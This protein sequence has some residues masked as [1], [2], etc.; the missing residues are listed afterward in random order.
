MPIGQAPCHSLLFV[1]R[2]ASSAK[3]IVFQIALQKF[4]SPTIL[5]ISQL[6]EVYSSLQSIVHYKWYLLHKVLIYSRVMSTTTTSISGSL[7]AIFQL[8]TIYLDTRTLLLSLLHLLFL[9][10][11][12]TIVY[13]LLIQA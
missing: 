13:M 12:Y 3:F 4:F 5:Y 1:K 6:S 10:N 7:W 9:F 2:I 8:S 11:F